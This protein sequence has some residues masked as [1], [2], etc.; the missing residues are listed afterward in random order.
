MLPIRATQWG[1]PVFGGGDVITA[2]I[3]E[4]VDLIV[5]REKLLC[6]TG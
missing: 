5:G 4:I 1:S 6:L 2:E 3:K